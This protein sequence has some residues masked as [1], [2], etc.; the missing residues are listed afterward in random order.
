MTGLGISIPDRYNSPLQ[1]DRTNHGDGILIYLASNLIYKRRNDLEHFWNESIWVEIKTKHDVYCLGVFYSPKRADQQFVNQ[2]NLNIEK[3]NENIKNIIIV[4]DLNEDLLNPNMYNL[5]NILLLK[6]MINIISEPTR[7][8]AILDQII[9]PTIW[10]TL[11][12]A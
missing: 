5:R 4:G 11:I 6:P 3:V 9:I 12:L 7:Q 8:Q 10:N 1:K 2:L